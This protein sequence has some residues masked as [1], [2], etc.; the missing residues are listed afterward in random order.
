[1]L[2]I[3]ERRRGAA[4][5]RLAD[6]SVRI[7]PVESDLVERD[8]ERF[9]LLLHDTQDE[10]VRTSPPVVKHAVGVVAVLAVP[11]SSLGIAGRALCGLADREPELEEEALV[12]SRGALLDERLDFVEG[13]E[14][15]LI[16]V[17]S[18]PRVAF[19]AA[20]ASSCG[21]WK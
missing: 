11:P 10:A 12:A 14:V 2:A 19:T 3:L 13:L 18:T 8:P 5:G 15:A 17:R 4:R 20:F 1:V 21:C 9:C 6:V 16:E 7:E